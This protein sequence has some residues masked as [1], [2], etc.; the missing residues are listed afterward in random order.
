MARLLLAALALICCTQQLAE[1]GRSLFISDEQAQ[2]AVQSLDQAAGQV[3]TQLT[4]ALAS[5][6]IGSTDS[7]SS[8]SESKLQNKTLEAINE[9]APFWKSPMGYYIR[10]QVMLT[11]SP[12]P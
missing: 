1:A 10:P 5:S 12:S 11:I 3:F 7:S 2:A 9:N 6:G 4:N 8:S